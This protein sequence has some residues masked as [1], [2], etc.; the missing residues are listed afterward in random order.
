MM[1]DPYMALTLFF[2]SK[3]DTWAVYHFDLDVVNSYHYV[4]WKYSVDKRNNLG[5]HECFGKL[6]MNIL[7]G[8]LHILLDLQWRIIQFMNIND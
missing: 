2:W 1:E 7:K 5:I 6:F 3:D 8:T 4:V